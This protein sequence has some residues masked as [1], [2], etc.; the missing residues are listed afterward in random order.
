M[1]F[2]KMLKDK[3]NITFKES[4]IVNVSKSAKYY[5][6]GLQ[7][8]V[9]ND[10]VKLLIDGNMGINSAYISLTVLQDFL[11]SYNKLKSQKE[12]T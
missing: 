7:I 6:G 11:N 9:E 1:R 8:N 3:P 10:V 5:A 4:H 2:M 12:D